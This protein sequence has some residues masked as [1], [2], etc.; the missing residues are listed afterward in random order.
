[1]YWSYCS[2]IP[3]SG[4]ICTQ[5]VHLPKQQYTVHTTTR[6]SARAVHVHWQFSACT[7][8]PAPRY[9]DRQLH[10]AQIYVHYPAQHIPPVYQIISGFLQLLL[11]PSSVIS[12]LLLNLYITILICGIGWSLH[13]LT[14]G[15]RG[16]GE[17][18]G[19]L[20]SDLCQTLILSSCSCRFVLRHPAPARPRPLHKGTVTKTYTVLCFTA[21]YC[22]LK[23]KV[24]HAN[25]V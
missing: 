21:V 5:A 11:I 7:V 15:E 6:P 17:G 4:S 9:Y 16:E 20:F 18:E 8:S 13:Q 10:A 14:D 25:R 22:R 3:S 19:L 23:S 24:M 2:L 1:M 12:R